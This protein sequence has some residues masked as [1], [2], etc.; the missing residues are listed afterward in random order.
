MD[1]KHFIL[2]TRYIA[3]MKDGSTID[4][5]LK[6]EEKYYFYEQEKEYLIIA[7]KNQENIDINNV[8]RIEKVFIPEETENE[9]Q[10]IIGV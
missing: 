4:I 10:I 3:I 9:V 8:L 7:L 6:P 5:V 2:R 1:K